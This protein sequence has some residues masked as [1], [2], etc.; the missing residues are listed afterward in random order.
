MRFLLQM[1]DSFIVFSHWKTLKASSVLT[2]D[3]L[4]KIINVLLLCITG[5]QVFWRYPIKNEFR[6]EEIKLRD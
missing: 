6:Y 2:H 3:R 1:I 4:W 5:G